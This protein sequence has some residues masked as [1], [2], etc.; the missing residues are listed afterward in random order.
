MIP[1]VVTNMT[2]QKGWGPRLLV[3]L[4]LVLVG[5]AAFYILWSQMQP[6]I[7]LK[8]GDGIFTA[9]LATT[10]VDRQT[11][12][13][14]TSQLSANQ[15]LILVFDTDDSWS[16]WMKG[17]NYPLDIVWLNQQKQVVYIV[18]NAQPDSYPNSSFE[19]SKPARYVIELAA[20]TV[21]NKAI[22]VGSPAVFDEK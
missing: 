19:P 17:M 6:R 2:D 13:S 22:Q 16:I 3:G 7:T 10:D 20:G 9:K 8:I 18:K 11:G 1:R 12:L 4:V 5:G 14:G 21:D 15:A